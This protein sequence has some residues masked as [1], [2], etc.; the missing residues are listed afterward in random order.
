M[1]LGLEDFPLPCDWA[2]SI[3]Y[4]NNQKE[5]NTNSQGMRKKF[6]TFFVIAVILVA[7]FLPKFL[8]S[9]VQK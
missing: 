9:S 3:F 1:V 4:S 6:Q 2:I 5:K 8:L 7:S